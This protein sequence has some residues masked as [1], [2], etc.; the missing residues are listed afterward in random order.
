MKDE[1]IKYE[2]GSQK[3]LAYR[4]EKENKWELYLFGNLCDLV[5]GDKKKLERYV[6]E[7]IVEISD[8]EIN[9]ANKRIE[10]ANALRNIGIEIG[11][12]GLEAALNKNEQ[13]T[14]F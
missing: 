13:K 12:K 5:E 3:I 6:S 9:E 10:N 7:K 4:H 1:E 14:N 11:K 8:A 2:L